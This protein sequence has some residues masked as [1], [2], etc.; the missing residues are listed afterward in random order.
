MRP[1]PGARRRVVAAR[2]TSPLPFRWGTYLTQTRTGHATTASTEKRK[3]SRRTCHRQQPGRHHEGRENY[4]QGLL[5]PSPKDRNGITWGR[6]AVNQG[7]E[8]H[9]Q[10]LE[11]GWSVIVGRPTCYFA[12]SRTCSFVRG[13]TC[14]V[15]WSLLGGPGNHAQPT[16]SIA[17]TPERGDHAPQHT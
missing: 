12:R 10:E 8:H 5:L 9:H 4:C 3:P 11:G 7:L 6:N 15:G 1:R 2:R 16:A 13:L 14:Y 17:E